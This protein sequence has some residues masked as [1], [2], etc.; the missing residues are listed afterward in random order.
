MS[1]F[2][3]PLIDLD[4]GN[5][6]KQK[7][8]KRRRLRALNSLELAA[9]LERPYMHI[10]S[11]ALEASPTQQHAHVHTVCISRFLYLRCPPLR[12]VSPGPEPQQN[13]HADAVIDGK[14]RVELHL[15]EVVQHG[16]ECS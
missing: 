7:A 15:P 2:I 4:D 8:R 1:H 16:G 14:R 10:A 11:Q 12:K 9:D 5:A 3:S 13:R 6:T